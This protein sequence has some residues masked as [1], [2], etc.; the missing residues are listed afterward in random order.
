MANLATNSVTRTTLLSALEEKRRH[1]MKKYLLHRLFFVALLREERQDGEITAYHELLFQKIQK[2][3]LGEPASGILL[4]YSNCIFHILEASSG[5]LYHILMDLATFED[6]G[7]QALLQ[8][9]K[10]LVM[11]HNIPTRLFAQWS[12]TK[13]EVP[14]TIGY[15][16]QVQ[17]TEEVITE[18]LTLVLKMGVYLATLKMNSKGLG[19]N[20]H[21]LVPELLIPAET[22]KYLC[23]TKECLSPREFLKMYYD[24]L[25]PQM[26]AETV[27]PTP[28]HLAV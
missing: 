25:Q 18:C 11:S 2:F 4:L 23:K 16:T 28:A 15:D 24:P 19:D 14:I 27:W 21:T 10:I 1:Q 3:H 6:E 8:D 20:L 22:I 26:D 9:I 5:T 7:P 13:V 12:A 17:S